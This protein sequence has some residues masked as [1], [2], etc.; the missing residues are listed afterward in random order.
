[1]TVMKEIFSSQHTT[2]PLKSKTFWLLNCEKKEK[3]NK[4][5][6]KIF[7]HIS[8]SHQK[9]LM[10]YFFQPFNID[11]NFLSTF[12]FFL[13]VSF[14]LENEWKR[15]SLP[16]AKLSDMQ[17]FL[18]NSFFLELNFFLDKFLVLFGSFVNFGETFVGM[19]YCIWNVRN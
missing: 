13:H 12:F 19:F 9:L 1:M 17:F 11:I 4:K 5:V 3:L 6:H 15:K 7:L 18:S 10:R 8:Y 2:I 14:K 16:L